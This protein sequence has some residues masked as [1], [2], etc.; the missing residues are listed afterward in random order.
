MTKTL[1]GYLLGV[2]TL[3]LAPSVIAQ[4]VTDEPVIDEPIVIDEPRIDPRALL[5]IYYSGKTELSF[6][7]TV[8]DRATTTPETVSLI[9]QDEVIEK[10]NNIEDKIN[11]LLKQ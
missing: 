1:F 3:V 4:V 5:P 8:L 7:E 6:M 10:L 9:Y 11:K 2:L